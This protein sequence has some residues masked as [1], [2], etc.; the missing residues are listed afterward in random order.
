MDMADTEEVLET[1]GTG[2]NA[3]QSVL[4]WRG[5]VLW[6]TAA[7]PPSSKRLIAQTEYQV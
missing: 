5:V 4:W 2:G 3:P 7:T 6:R 1:T